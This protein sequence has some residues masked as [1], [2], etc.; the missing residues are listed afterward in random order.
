TDDSLIRC[1]SEVRRALG[2]ESQAIIKT[3]PR[4]GYLLDAPVLPGRESADAPAAEA[5]LSGSLHGEADRPAT[6]QLPCRPS[7][8]VLP[9]TNLSG[10]PEED[11]LA[12]GISEDITTELS[13]FSVSVREHIESHESIVIQQW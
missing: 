2:D 13:R 5:P 7:I 11:Y 1:I 8:V 10:K 9:F 3:V 12:N 6:L 4:R